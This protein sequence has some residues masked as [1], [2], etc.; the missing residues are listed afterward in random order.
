MSFQTTH[1]YP[2]FEVKATLGAQSQ[3]PP[4]S[5]MS[6]FQLYNAH[7]LRSTVRL[8]NLKQEDAD[9]LHFQDTRAVKPSHGFIPL[10]PSQCRAYGR[11]LIGLVE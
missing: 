5:G 10:S 9:S 3:I 1:K 4:V 6:T 2:G 8:W 11:H 7:I